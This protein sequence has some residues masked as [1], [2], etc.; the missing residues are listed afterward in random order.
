MITAERRVSDGPGLAPPMMEVQLGAWL[1]FDHAATHHASTEIVSKTAD[2]ELHRYTYSDFARRTQKLMHALDRLGLEP[3]DRVATLAWSH[4]RHLEA[5]FGI[6]CTRRVVHTLNP[7]LSIADLAYII[8]HADDRAILVDPDLLPLLEQLGDALGGVKHVVVL[9]DEV[10]ETSLSGVIS[11]EDL[12]ADES[13]AYPRQEIDERTPLGYC[14]T[15]GTTGR[16]KGVVY[17]HRS[18]FLHA[19]AVSSGAGFGIGPQDTVLPVV[20]MFHANAWGLPHAATAVGAKQVYPGPHL[21]GKSLV[22]LCVG[23]QVT[24]TGGV[25]TIWMGVAEELSRRGI[26][27]PHMR[28]LVC[29][30]SQ[31]PRPLIERFQREFGLPI[32]QAWGM[33][34][35]SPLASVAWPKVEMRDWDEDRLTRVVKTQ[36]GIPLPGMQVSI[37]SYAGED[38]PW[39]GKS[40][41]D[42]LVRGPW[43]LGSYLHGEGQEQFTADGWLRTGDVAIGSPD[44][45]FVIADRTKDLIK[46][47]GEWISSVDMEGAIMAMPDVIEAAV[48]AIPDDK[49]QERPLACVVPRPGASVTVEDVREHLLQSGF[50]KWQL[51]ARIELIDAVPLTGVRKFDKKALRLGFPV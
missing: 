20:P 31:P 35:T 5:Y 16:P 42:L 12:I 39:D 19:L 26:R 8:G 28:H 2:G 49:W 24:V 51:P 50:A 44:G 30:G 22:D 47:G 40:M 10:P 6:P 25:P 27:L 37:R 1:L 48:I 38:V 36:A 33:T 13:D 9:G 17:T 4:Y 41:G 43:V 14:Y 45:Y 21:D 7:R 15:S 29:G 3:G 11:Y 18:I 23:E 32:V 46:S 34:E